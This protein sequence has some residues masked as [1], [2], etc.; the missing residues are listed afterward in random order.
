MMSY[1]AGGLRQAPN[2]GPA[3]GSEVV[4]DQRPHK[5]QIRVP[6]SRPVGHAAGQ[7]QRR[8]VLT[9]QRKVQQYV[10]VVD[11]VL[12]SSLLLTGQR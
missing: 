7:E 11:D 4:T 8:E 6:A 12:E 3:A 5:R 9:A 10:M 2:L 1:S